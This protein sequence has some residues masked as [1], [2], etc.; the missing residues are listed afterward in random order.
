[1]TALHNVTVS[2]AQN[3][4]QAAS[5]PVAEQVRSMLLCIMY[6]YTAWCP[7]VCGCIQ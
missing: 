1:M 3:G 2:V 6:I 5:L 4:S 7:L